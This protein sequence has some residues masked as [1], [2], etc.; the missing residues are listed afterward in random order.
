MLVLVAAGCGGSSLDASTAP[1]TDGVQVSP[2]R[3]LADTVA[4]ASGISEFSAALADAG[5]TA[6]KARLRAVVNRLQPPLA[7]TTAIAE[8]LGAERL[9]DRRLE[10]Q[11]ASAS[12]ALDRVV[13]AMTAV[14]SAAALGDPAAV[15]T[16]ATDFATAVG[17][18][19]SLPA[20]P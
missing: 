20:N 15:E 6:T 11:R 9:A 4:A 3:Y 13:V 12:A 14:A 7:R 10:A 8:R 16:A 5:P 19:R 2:R 17:D 1:L 18:M